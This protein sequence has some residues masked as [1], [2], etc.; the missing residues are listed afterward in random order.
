MGEELIRTNK[1]NDAHNSFKM[2]QMCKVR[3]NGIYTQSPKLGI[4]MLT[5]Y[6]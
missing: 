1:T 3:G 2:E 5:S 4:N 6:I